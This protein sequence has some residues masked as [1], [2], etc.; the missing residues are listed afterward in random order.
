MVKKF[1][2]DDIFLKQR[3]NISGVGLVSL[4]GGL[5]KLL[6]NLKRMLIL[7]CFLDLLQVER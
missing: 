2:L 7:L 1:L 6:L 4:R 5:K 3:E